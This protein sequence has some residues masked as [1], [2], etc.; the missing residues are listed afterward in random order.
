M[1]AGVLEQIAPPE[2]LYS[3]PA[4]EFVAEFVGLTNRLR[5][6]VHDGTADVGGTKLS[7]LDGSLQDG[8]G[9]ALVRPEAVRVTPSEQGNALVSRT[10]FLGAISRLQLETDSGLSLVAQVPR[11]AVPGLVVG[12]RV[13]V[14]I[15]HVPVL[16]VAD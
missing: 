5:A 15:D 8:E 13:D 10:S 14:S 2:T 4:T 12:D 6:T 11:T 9:T 3:A 16:V 7:T 1:R